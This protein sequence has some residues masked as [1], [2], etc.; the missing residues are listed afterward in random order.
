M[1]QLAITFLL[2]ILFYTY[3]Q[4]SVFASI[5]GGIEYSIPTDYS[6]LSEQELANKADKY[7]FLA[8]KYDDGVINEDITN[9]LFLYSVLQH[10]NP[11]K[12][13]YAVRQG[14]LYDKLGIDRHAKGCFSKAIAGKSRAFLYVKKPSFL[15]KELSI[16]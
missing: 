16:L 2:I 5:K 10:K 11:E 15:L 4:S 9:A 6:K 1:R 3:S 14:V 7:Y 13:I 12:I 8:K